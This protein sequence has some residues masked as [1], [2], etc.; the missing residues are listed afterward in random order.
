MPARYCELS[1]T[2]SDNIRIY[3]AN[4]T[5][6]ADLTDTNLWATVSYPD[7][8]NQHT[9]NLATNR[10]TDFLAAG[11]KHTTDSGS[12]WKDGGSDLTGYDEQY[13]DIDTSGDVGADGVPIITIYC[14]EPSITFYIDTTIGLT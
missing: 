9:F 4:I 11:T 6:N 3:F 7:G 12:A 13:M 1:S 2:A 5:S 14:G 8:T 10:N